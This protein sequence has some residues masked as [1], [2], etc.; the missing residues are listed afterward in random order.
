MPLRTRCGSIVL[1]GVFGNFQVVGQGWAA[2]VGNG[3]K[4]KVVFIKKFIQ[5]EYER[6]EFYE[7]VDNHAILLDDLAK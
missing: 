6:Q 2:W 7:N 5:Y 4:V 1:P 3:R